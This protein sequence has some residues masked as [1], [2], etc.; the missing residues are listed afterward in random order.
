MTEELERNGLGSLVKQLES[1]DADAA[2]RVDLANPVRVIR[3]IEKAV[4]PKPTKPPKLPEFAKFKFAPRIEPD[5]LER[6][7]EIRV[8]K[9]VH[10]GWA[11]EI[12]RL[13][14]QGYRPHDPGFRAIGYR[15]MWDVVENGK[16]L[17]QAIAETVVETRQYAK[18]QRTW[19]RTEPNLIRLSADSGLETFRQA[20]KSLVDELN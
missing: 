4:G 19:L 7:I 15:Q 9:M 11:L 6:R 5:E 3:A 2:S 12:E 17:A 14:E 1:L 16:E 8:G 13:R 20:M 18:R 10:N